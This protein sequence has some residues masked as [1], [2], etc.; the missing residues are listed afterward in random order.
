LLDCLRRII[1][2]GGAGAGDDGEN[3]VGFFVVFALLQ[4][5]GSAGVPRV[6][7]S[8]RHGPSPTLV[9]FARLV[10]IQAPEQAGDFLAQLVGHCRT[11]KRTVN[12]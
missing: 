10:A 2:R 7:P 3:G 9:F 12:P 5:A 4:D 11:S 8:F 6:R 1:Q